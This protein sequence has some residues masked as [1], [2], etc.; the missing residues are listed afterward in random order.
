M[1]PT[2][3]RTAPRVGETVC[4]QRFDGQWT[5][6]TVLEVP[7]IAFGMTPYVVVRASNGIVHIPLFRLSH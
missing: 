4:W 6:G 2:Q 7:P 3:R 1:T 5:C